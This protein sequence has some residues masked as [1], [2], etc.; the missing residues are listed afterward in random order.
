[1][2]F[3]GDL[4]KAAMNSAIQHEKEVEKWVERYESYSTEQL[5]DMIK[6]HRFSQ[7]QMIG[8]R[9]ILRERGVID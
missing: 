1:M 8:V 4:G 9:R 6:K 2:G 3:W 5:V 7:N